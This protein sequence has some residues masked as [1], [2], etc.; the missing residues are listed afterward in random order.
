MTSRIQTPLTVEIK[1]LEELVARGY[2]YLWHFAMA[3]EKEASRLMAG[4]YE[5]ES[6]K[7]VKHQKQ[8]K[9]FRQCEGYCKEEFN[10][11][12]ARIWQRRAEKLYAAGDFDGLLDLRRHIE[13]QSFKPAEYKQLL[14]QR[15]HDLQQEITEM[16]DAARRHRVI[17]MREKQVLSPRFL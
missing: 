1:M 17:A 2:A 16:R 10:R 7:V 8:K 15:H 6:W 5:G 3:R 14:Q 9:I 13:T 12:L 4:A 11:G